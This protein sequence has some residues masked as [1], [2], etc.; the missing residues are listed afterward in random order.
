MAQLVTAADLNAVLAWYYLLGAWGTA[1]GAMSTGWMVQVLEHR[2]LSTLM[3]YKC[4]F[5]VYSLMGVVK[6]I[7][8]VVLSKACEMQ[9]AKDTTNGECDPSIA[10]EAQPFLP[11][12]EPKRDIDKNWITRLY[13]TLCRESKKF[14]T[15]FCLIISLDNFGSG[16]ASNSWLT[17]FITLKYNMQPGFLG[18][19]FFGSHLLAS[20]SN[21]IAIPVA[22]KVGLVATMVLGHVPASIALLLLPFPPVVVGTITCLLIRSI[23]IEF[24]QAPRQAFLA[25]AI[26]PEE[27]T[28]VM[29]VVNVVRTLSRTFA[30]FV[31]GVLGG[32]NGRGGY[33]GIGLAISLAGGI[34]LVY[35]VLFFSVFGVHDYQKKMQRRN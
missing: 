30:P 19:I 7:L 34:K 2:G 6:L 17:Y 1:A 24:D 26:L 10:M 5:Y 31:T 32:R 29:G 14:L 21:L 11:S 23:F 15:K 3:A 4:M 28:P 16:L 25:H 8:S 12:T 13:P 27:R 18:S 35:D 9:M 22:E 33:D 20:V